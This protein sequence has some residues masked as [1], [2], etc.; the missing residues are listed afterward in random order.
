MQNTFNAMM[1]AGLDDFFHKVNMH[2]GEGLAVIAW[3]VE[4][5]HKIYQYIMP[6]ADF[7]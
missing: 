3:F 1:L 2:M 5:A 7:D 4:D 6:T